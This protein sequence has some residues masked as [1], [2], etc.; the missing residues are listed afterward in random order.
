MRCV[1]WPPSSPSF[2]DGATRDDDSDGVG[3]TSEASV[4]KH[5]DTP[6]DVG[7]TVTVAAG[8]DDDSDSN[9]KHN[10]N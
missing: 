1:A 7:A 2:S 4:S 5:V 10:G 3:F 6:S 9:S 8:D